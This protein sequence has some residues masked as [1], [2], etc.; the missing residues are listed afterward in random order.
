MEAQQYKKISSNKVVPIEA[1]A[2]FER[3]YDGGARDAVA[4]EKF[5]GSRFGV[6]KDLKGNFKFLSTQLKDRTINVPD[7]VEALHELNIPNDTILD[8]EVVHLDAPKELRWELSRSTMGTKAY[9]TDVE[10]PHLVIFDCQR[11]NGIDLTTGE[12]RFIDRREVLKKFF[13]GKAMLE[14]KT[15]TSYGKLALPELFT[16]N[17]FGA[18]FLELHND[19]GEGIMIKS[20]AST[21]YGKDWIKVKHRFTVDVIVTGATEG[22]NK[23]K[24][25]IGALELGMMDSDGEIISIGKCSGMSDEERQEF[26]KE[27]PKVIEV[28]AFEV[29]KNLKLRHPA[30]MRV[31]DDKAQKRCKLKQLEEILNATGK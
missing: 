25:L 8:C 3:R 20:L 16:A 10:R 24:G 30:F 13:E 27:L 17:V 21:K 19:K 9:N 29:T 5:D 2:E 31:R 23:Y 6:V 22:K 26:T 14:N 11:V 7:L 15:Y 18:L 12:Y 1:L 4:E 28:T